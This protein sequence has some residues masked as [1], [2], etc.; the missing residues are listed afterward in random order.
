MEIQPI[1]SNKPMMEMPPLKPNKTIK[2]SI[3][4]FVIFSILYLSLSIYFSTHFYFGTVIN[5]INASGKTVEQ[6]DKEMSLKYKTY[7]LQLQERGGVKEQINAADIGLKYNSKDKIQVL[8]DN[9]NSIAWINEIFK[10]KDTKLSGIVTYDEKLLKK[11][12][13]MLSCVDSKKIIEPKNASFK[14]SNNAYTIVKEVKGNKLNSKNLYTNIVNSILSGE[15]Q[16][17]LETTNQYI[18]PKYTSTSKEAKN[19][20]ILLDKYIASKIT[21]T[22]TGGQQGLDRAEIHNWLIVNKDLTISF[23]QNKMKN[24]V[25]ELSKNYNTYGKERDFAT[26]VGTK[27]EVSGG[28][29]GWL[30]DRKGEINDLIVAIKG[31]QTITKQPNYSQTAVSHNINDIGNTYVEINITKQHLWFY[32]NGALVVDGD[33]VTGN[34]SE[35]LATPDGVY[36]LKY[37][38]KNATL[39]GPGYSEPVNCFMPFNGGIGIHGAPWRSVFGGNIYL[40]GGSHGCVN[41]SDSLAIKIF[42][43][44][45]VNTPVIC[46]IQ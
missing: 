3:I 39:T 38:E 23:N 5:E 25:D 46:Y 14:Y 19:T 13:D 2:V 9:Q 1:K 30:V 7:T 34:V 43:N 37:K 18:N 36:R 12:F 42:N 40:S 35:K 26:S 6:L 17:N 45:D 29:Y 32:K 41:A 22:F 31:G 24:Y 4:C 11:R 8:K 28:D 44:I 21:Y 16:V 27:V 10:P 15:T 33:V 20:K